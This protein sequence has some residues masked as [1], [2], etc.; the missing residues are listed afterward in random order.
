MGITG[1]KIVAIRAFIVEGGGAD[2][3][4][5][6]TG[7]WIVN[8]IATPMSIYPE[9]KKTRTSF[10]INALKSLVVEVEADNGV[11]GFAIS[12]GV[13]PAA[14]LVM[15]HLDRFVV[16][17]PVENIEKIWDQLYRSSMY[18]GRKG[19][20]MNAISAIDLALWDLLGKLRQ[21]PV[22]AMIG[23]KVRDELSFYATGPRPD[24]AKQMGFIGGKMPLTY[25]PAD[26][27]E[28]LNLNMKLAAEMREKVGN[29]FWLMWDCW[30]ALDLPYA[31]QLMERSGALGFKWVEECF[32]P[33]DYWSYRDL[34]KRAPN[35]MMITGGE[36][37][38]TRYGFRLLLEYCDLDIIQPDVTWC[39]GLT[40]LIKIGNLAKAYNKLVIPHGSGVYS[41]QYVITQTNSP[42]SEYLMISPKADKVVPQFYPLLSNEPVPVNGRL[43][44]GDEPGFGVGLNRQGLVE[45]KKH[46]P[47]SHP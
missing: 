7:H 18:Y 45:L 12:T 14:W 19:L 22:Y 30:M 37:E 29:D 40:E 9:Y 24:L 34:K 31:Q 1:R 41:N 38:A 43:K 27:E 20:A 2:Y 6:D 3:H 4:D 32:N 26:N 35:T 10:G 33:D 17:Q 25:G 23:G 36:H 5:Q 42:F 44:V 21:E 15:N 11:T 8:Q 47:S 16:G 28:G 39:G 13:Y 46:I